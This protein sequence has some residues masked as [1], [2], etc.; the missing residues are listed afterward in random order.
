[1]VERKVLCVQEPKEVF[2]ARVAQY[3]D[4]EGLAVSVG[5]ERRSA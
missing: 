3:A 4:P 5:Q 1:M 2:G